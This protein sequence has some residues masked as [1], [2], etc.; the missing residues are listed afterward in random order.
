MPVASLGASRC[1]GGA[2]ASVGWHAWQPGS[3]FAPL[4]ALR[5]APGA[6]NGRRRP[7]CGEWPA[8]ELFV[9]S[10]A[11]RGYLGGLWGPTD[12]RTAASD[13]TVDK[14]SPTAGLCTY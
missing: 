5:A 6:R 4:R 14:E 9:S 13:A 2:D 12:G 7:R 8:T 10:S 11:F 1:I 3:R